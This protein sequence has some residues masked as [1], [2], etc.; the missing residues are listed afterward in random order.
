MSLASGS[1]FDVSRRKSP[2][3]VTSPIGFVCEFSS[4]SRSFYKNPIGVS[5]SFISELNEGMSFL[6]MV[7][8]KYE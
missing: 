3:V 1:A 4:F 8:L 5:L 7:S 2:R 6:L